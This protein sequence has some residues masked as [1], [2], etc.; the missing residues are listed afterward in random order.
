MDLY[1]ELP[2]SKLLYDS[3]FTQLL[4]S[5]RRYEVSVID[6]LSLNARELANLTQRSITEVIKFQNALFGEL[7]NQF[8]KKNK[9]VP[10]MDFEGPHPFTTGDVTLDELL[11]GGIYTQSIT[12]IFGASSTGKSQLLMQMALSVQL[13]RQTN[14]LGGK[15]VYITTEGDL[16]TK[17]LEEMIASRD[18]FTE[19]C[20]SQ[21]NIFTVS[22]NDLM[23]Q[24]HILNVQLPV[25]L[26]RNA[27]D[28]KLVIIDSISHHLRVEL[29]NKSYQEAQENKFYIDQLAESLLSIATKYDIAIVVANQ[30][31]DKPVIDPNSLTRQFI[32]DFDYQL[33]YMV[34]WKSSSI[35]YRYKHGE[36]NS[37]KLAKPQLDV[38]R[39]IANDI[40]SDDDEYSLIADEMDKV[41]RERNSQEQGSN[42]MTKPSQGQFKDRSLEE[43]DTT[44]NSKPAGQDERSSFQV[45]GKM[46]RKLDNRVPNL[47]ISWANH[48]AT[49]IL[50]SKSYKASPMI[51]RG[52]L[53]LYNSFDD[54]AFWQVKR[55]INLVFSTYGESG[56]ANYVI[57][58]S[59]IEVVE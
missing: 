27:G 49:R 37:Y 3:E 1:D 10:I 41:I 33:G 15:C 11:N 57:S 47:G 20:V 8:Q 56:E 51:R 12:E 30:V 42:N 52:E 46:K 39:S 53:T 43:N 17:R 9:I 32:T 13:P 40:L 16:P 45:Y 5:C 25:L 19:N 6:F 24:E 26:E 59:G 29:V 22:C 36:I 23:N 14:G 2:Q 38:H 50:L 54:S 35:M 4:E 7:N 31:S 28:I 55:T 18:E 44:R 58:P 48:I 34:G 21:K